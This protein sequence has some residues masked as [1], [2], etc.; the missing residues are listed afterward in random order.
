L[1]VRDLS[2]EVIVL[3]KYKILFVGCGN[4]G[5][6]I[7]RGIITSGYIES[8][9]IVF[10]E[11]DKK[12]IKYIEKTYAVKSVKNIGEGIHYSEYILL[13]V[14][15][16]NI[17]QVL[18]DIRKYFDKDINPLIS[19]AAGISTGFIERSL[20]CKCSVM[21]VMPNAPALF[22][23]GMTAISS[24]KYSSKNDQ[25]FTRDLMNQIGECIIIDEGLQNIATAIS[26]SGPAYFFLFCKYIIETAVKN[27]IPEDDARTLVNETMIGSGIMIGKSGLEVDKLISRVASPGGTTE[28]ALKVLTKKCFE[29]IISRAIGEAVKRSIELEGELR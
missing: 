22:N 4:M 24:G 27:G 21:R 7:L 20:G 12:R 13:C 23:R 26:G 28:K 1:S 6:A 10:Y 16:Q 17:K 3:K 9:D 29:N 18:K 8:K 11:L 19:I 25:Q 14:K 2:G 5:E 15:P